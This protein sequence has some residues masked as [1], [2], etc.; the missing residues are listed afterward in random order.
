M[1]WVLQLQPRKAVVEE[2]P[3]RHEQMLAQMEDGKRDEKSGH[4]VYGVVYMPKQD[5]DREKD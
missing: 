1:N 3:I 5:D 4:D 2:V